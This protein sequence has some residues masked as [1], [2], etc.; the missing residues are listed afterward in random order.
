MTH[1]Q[2]SR[3]LLSERAKLD[4]ESKN[5]E[6]RNKL[7]KHGFT[8]QRCSAISPK[9]KLLQNRDKLT[10]Y[11]IFSENNKDKQ[12]DLKQTP[13]S[14]INKANQD[15]VKIDLLAS[16]PNTESKPVSK[17]EVIAKQS[18]IHIEEAQDPK[19]ELPA[20]EDNADSKKDVEND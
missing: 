12:V 18:P 20:S 14:K 19:L 5:Y 17:G 16:E 2:L 1:R 4:Q 6:S 3:H 13:R 9:N 8:T 11:E 7:K 10:E 15:E